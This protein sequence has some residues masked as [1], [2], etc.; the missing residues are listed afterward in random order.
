MGCINGGLIYAYSE[1]MVQLILS[2]RVIKN[3][4]FEEGIHTITFTSFFLNGEN[5]LQGANI[6]TQMGKFLDRDRPHKR[7]TT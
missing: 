1:M 6:L 7:I 3:L 2:T 4:G 5:T